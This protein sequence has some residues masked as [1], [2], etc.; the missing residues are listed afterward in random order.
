MTRCANCKRKDV[1]PADW[2]RLRIAEPFLVERIRNVDFAGNVSLGNLAGDIQR[3]GAAAKPCG[4]YNARLQDCVVGDGTRIANVGSHLAGYRVGDHVLIENIGV[5]ETHAGATF[6]NGVEVAALNEAGGREVPLFNALSSQ[7]AYLVCVHRYRTE[8]LDKLL[9]MAGREVD[10]ATR[11]FGIVGDGATIVGVP[12]IVDV[13]I[14]PAASIDSAQSLANGT[15]LSHPDVPT[16]IG[17]AVIAKDFIV[18]E[19]GTSQRR[20][21]YP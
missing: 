18:A 16:I 2:S 20:R 13:N 19:G 3:K 5:M 17:E 10:R 11:D 4:V 9:A 14:G 7:F 8:L 6:G 1:R 15:I 12:R 21:H